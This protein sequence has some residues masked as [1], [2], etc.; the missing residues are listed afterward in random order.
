ML[1]LSARNDVPNA[2]PIVDVSAHFIESL[3]REYDLA[4]NALG[5]VGS[6]GGFIGLHMDA[7]ELVIGILGLEFPQDNQDSL[8]PFLFGAYYDE[9]WCER[10][11]YGLNDS[12]WSQ[13]SWIDSAM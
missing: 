9:D 11:P 6:E 7:E 12:E 3:F 13:Y 4:V 8:L 2:A 5:W 10:D 1:L